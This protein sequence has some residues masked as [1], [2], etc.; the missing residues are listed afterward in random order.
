L[1]AALVSVVIGTD[2]NKKSSATPTASSTDQAAAAPLLDCM[3]VTFDIAD[4]LI[5]G[6]TQAAIGVVGIQDPRWRI[7][8]AARLAFFR[9]RV[10]SG[11]SAAAQAK[12]DAVRSGCLNLTN[13]GGT[14]ESGTSGGGV[15]TTGAGQTP[16]VEPTYQEPGADGSVCG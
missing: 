15:P 14:S 8:L 5:D 4:Y 10:Q 2:T 6:D 13:A 9:V 7:A 11:D 1:V 12:D 16:C 3:R